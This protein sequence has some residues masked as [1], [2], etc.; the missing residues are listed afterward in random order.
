MISEVWKIVDSKR[1]VARGQWSAAE[2]KSLVRLVTIYGVRNWSCIAERLGCRIGKQCREHSHL[3]PDIKKQAWSVEE[4]KAFIEAHKKYGNRLAGRS[5]NAIKNRWNTYR[6]K[7]LLMNN[8]KK[9]RVSN[10]ISSELLEHMASSS[11]F[12]S[13]FLYADTTSS[14]IWSLEKE[15]NYSLQAKTK[16]ATTNFKG[17]SRTQG[18]LFVGS[19]GKQRLAAAT[20]G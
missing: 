20:T 4:D 3:C 6:R 13:K 10:Q 2:D 15:C 7:Y 16:P 18:I 1:F 5:E 9:G 19:M 12:T 14:S 8:Q 17:P 11:Q